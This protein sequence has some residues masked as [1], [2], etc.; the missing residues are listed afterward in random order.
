M[1]NSWF[2]TLLLEDVNQSLN[3]SEPQFPLL[4]Q[5][6]LDIKC[7]APARRLELCGCYGSYCDKWAA[8]AALILPRAQCL[9]LYL[10]FSMLLTAM[11][12]MP[13]ITRWAHREGAVDFT[14]DAVSCSSTGGENPGLSVTI[15]QLL[16]VWAGLVRNW[17]QENFGDKLF[18]PLEVLSRDMASSWSWRAMVI[19][20]SGFFNFILF[21]QSFSSVLVQCNKLQNVT[22]Q[23]QVQRTFPLRDDL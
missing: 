5:N 21:E 13:A 12:I 4:R 14:L 20:G 7:K 6:G 18:T 17:S 11:T 9:S 2:S 1:I 10:A 23:R 16:A 15:S 22:F 8:E 3:L 19:S